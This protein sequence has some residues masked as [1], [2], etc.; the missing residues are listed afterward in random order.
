MEWLIIDTSAFVT[1]SSPESDIMLPKR[2]SSEL[3]ALPLVWMA[4]PGTIMCPSVVPGPS[5][6]LEGLLVMKET[7]VAAPLAAAEF[8]LLENLHPGLCTE[9]TGW[10][11][12]AKRPLRLGSI[13]LCAGPRGREAGTVS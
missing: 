9:G 4:A 10:V 2:V 3:S 13:L 1:H 6:A 8:V 5:T 12:G 7:A 11:A